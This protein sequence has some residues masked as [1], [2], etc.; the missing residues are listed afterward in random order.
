MRLSTRD[1]WKGVLSIMIA[2]TIC[3]PTGIAD[4]EIFLPVFAG[5]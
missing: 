3:D 2:R 5:V 1:D 4:A